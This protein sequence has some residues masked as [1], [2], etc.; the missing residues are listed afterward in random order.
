[1]ER[2]LVGFHVEG[3]DHLVLM[4]YLAKLLDIS[5]DQIEPDVIERG[6]RGWLAVL[7]IAPKAL[8][9]FYGKCARCAVLAIDNDGNEDLR[10]SGAIEDPRHPRHANHVGTSNED[11]RHCQL[12]QIVMRTRPELNWIPA[13]PGA[14]WPVVIAVPVEAVEAWIL[15]T[16]AIVQ[17]NDAPSFHAEQLRRSVLKQR[18]YG[19]PYA[20]KTD[21]E[22]VAWPL[23]RELTAMRIDSLRSYS[24]S[25]S[26][27][28]E[29][30]AIYREAILTDPGCWPSGT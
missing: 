6:N 3:W 5:E 13:K 23:I 9:R 17:G 15:A 29:Q 7:E 10:Q 19:K 21:V 14:A 28:F 26:L 12:D 4:A 1:M 27:F 16:R 20:T 8:K 22:R 18:L 2:L 25:F 30:V 24:R 11:C